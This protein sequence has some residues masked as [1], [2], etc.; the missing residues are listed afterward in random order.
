MNPYRP[1]NSFQCMVL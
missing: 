1:K